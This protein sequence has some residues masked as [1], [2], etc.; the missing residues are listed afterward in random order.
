MARVTI[1]TTPTCPYCIAALGLLRKKGVHFENVNVAGDPKTR[2]WLVGA[3]GGRTT[4]P[5]IFVDGRPYGG[6]DDIAALD[7]QGKLDAILAGEAVETA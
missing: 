1:Y 5:Q 4:V 3:S 7:R 6:Y 2:Q